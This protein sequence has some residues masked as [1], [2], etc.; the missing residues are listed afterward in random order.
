M[1]GRRYGTNDSAAMPK[2]LLSRLPI[3]PYIASIL[4]MVALA[5]ALPAH[6]RG[7]PSPAGAVPA[8]IALL[9]FLQGARLA[10]QAALAGA[11]HW[12]LHAVV[13]GST[14]VLFPLL[15][16]ALRA[17]RARAADAAA[18]GRAAVAVPCCPRPCSP[19]SPSPRS[20]AA[21]SPAAL[22]AAPRRTCSASC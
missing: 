8:A 5:S 20:R 7:M 13:L 22:C 4:G 16:L 2:T 10:P 6:G 14:F 19:R 18:L 1:S 12:R 15:G 11:R 3:D 9:F 17:H 21:M